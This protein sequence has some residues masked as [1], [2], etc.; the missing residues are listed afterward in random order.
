MQGLFQNLVVL[1]TQGLLQKFDLLVTQ[2]LFQIVDVYLLQ[3]LSKFCQVGFMQVFNFVELSSITKI[4]SFLS[5][6]CQQ[7]A[8]LKLKFNIH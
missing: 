2:G 6:T 7:K 8:L 4:L 5:H 3:R 1:R